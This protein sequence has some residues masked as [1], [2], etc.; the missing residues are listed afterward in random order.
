MKHAACGVFE[1][2]AKNPWGVRTRG[3]ANNELPGGSFKCQSAGPEVIGVALK[4]FKRTLSGINIFS[5]SAV[6]VSYSTEII[7]NFYYWLF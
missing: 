3:T 6:R 1:P 2:I 7:F 5:Y 4:G